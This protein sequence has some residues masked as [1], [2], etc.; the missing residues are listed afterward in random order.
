MAKD[1]AG[2]AGAW[3]YGLDWRFLSAFGIALVVIG[4]VVFLGSRRPPP[5]G[6]LCARRYAQAH[7]ARDSA[8]IDADTPTSLGHGRGMGPAITCGQLRRLGEVPKR[9]WPRLNRG[10]SPKNGRPFVPQYR[11]ALAVLRQLPVV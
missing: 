7:T 11:P 10:L 6:E 5:G 1:L 8:A 2:D 3:R 4:V 9:S